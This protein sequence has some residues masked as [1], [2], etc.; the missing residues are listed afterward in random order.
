MSIGGAGWQWRGIRIRPKIT[1]PDCL[2]TKRRHC[3]FLVLGVIGG[4]TVFLRLVAGRSDT[5][6]RSGSQLEATYDTDDHRSRNMR[7]M[8]SFF[9]L[10]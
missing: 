10:V 6:R 5:A 1:R 4:A 9:G 7:S 2:S 3:L 8:S